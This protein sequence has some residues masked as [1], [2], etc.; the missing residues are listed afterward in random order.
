[1][2]RRLVVYARALE[3]GGEEMQPRGAELTGSASPCVA[4]ALLEDGG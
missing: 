4:L 1:M 2:I 3:E